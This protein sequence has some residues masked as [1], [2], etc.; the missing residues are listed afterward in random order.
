[1]TAIILMNVLP[2]AGAKNAPASTLANTLLIGDVDGDNAVTIVDATAIQRR[3]ANMSQFNELQE[4]L[5]DTDGDDVLSVIDATIVQRRIAELGNEFWRTSIDPRRPQIL[6]FQTS[7]YYPNYRDRATAVYAKTPVRLRCFSENY[8]IPNRIFT[9]RYTFY[10]NDEPIA[11]DSTQ[12]SCLYRFEEA[13]TY[14]VRTVVHNIFGETATINSVTVLDSPE[15]PYL[16]DAVFDSSKMTLSVQGAG[17]TGGYEYRCYIRYTVPAEPSMPPT[18]EP[19][20]G[21][22][23]PSFNPVPR[24][25]GTYQLV[26]DYTTAS[27][28]KI[29][30]EMLNTE[31]EYSIY[32]TVKDSSGAESDL[33]QIISYQSF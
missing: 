14:T 28:I 26:S 4:F 7:A 9:N 1:M 16:A 23:E 11:V 10:L 12:N 19:T 3:L 17:G 22:T 21:D 31:M 2:H 33:S 29:P 32:I 6:S 18:E 25:D 13:G 20:E 5:G 8:R 15:Q 24:P 27:T 30:N